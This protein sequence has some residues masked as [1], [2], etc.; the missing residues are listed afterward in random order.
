[1]KLNVYSEKILFLPNIWNCHSGF[2]V[3]RKKNPSPLIKNKYITFGSFNNANKVSDEVVNVWSKILKNINNSRLVL[4][5]SHSYCDKSLKKKFEKNKVLNQITF[6]DTTPFCGAS[7]IDEYKKIDLALDTFPY[8]GVTTS[9]E[10]IWMGAPLLT[11]KGFNPN[12]RAGE[13]INQ[14]L[15][16]NYLIANNKDE[17]VLKA[18]ELSNNFEKVIEIRKN[19]FDKALAPVF[20]LM[21]KSF[22]KNFMKI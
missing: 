22:Q 15:D 17:Y 12:S 20:S 5:S 18:V 2:S 9:F 7:I 21:I 11:L 10:A 6:L 1:M 3:L 16:M 8:N 14:N 19:L 13:S 4:K